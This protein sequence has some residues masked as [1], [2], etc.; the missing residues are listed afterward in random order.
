MAL[1]HE[2]SNGKRVSYRVTTRKALICHIKERI[3]LHFF[4]HV[5]DL[6]PLILCW[7]DSCRV[8]GASMQQHYASLGCSFQVCN[9][10]IKVQADRI[11]IVVPV[12]LNLKARVFEDSIVVGP[13]RSWDEDL[14]A[15]GIESSEELATDSQRTCARY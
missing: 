4:Y 8:M 2:M 9:H 7:I 14:F 13:T 10:T 6:A 3:M 11:L 5:A 1:L 12:L 15:A